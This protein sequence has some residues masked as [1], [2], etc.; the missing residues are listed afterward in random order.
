MWFFKVLFYVFLKMEARIRDQTRN[1]Q[2]SSS[3]GKALNVMGQ[4]EGEKSNSGCVIG[5]DEF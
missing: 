3:I 2:P 1:N 4:M 5:G